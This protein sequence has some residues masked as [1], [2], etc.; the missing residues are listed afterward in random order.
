MSR[1]ASIGRI[2]RAAGLF[3]GPVLFAGALLLD[4][5][6]LVS[7]GLPLWAWQTFAALLFVGS[8]AAIIISQ[9]RRIVELETRSS[10]QA[11]DRELENSIED[12]ISTK[13]KIQAH[14]LSL[15]AILHTLGDDLAVGVSA[16]TGRIVEQLGEAPV[17]P[18]AV[19]TAA[20]KLI[21]KQ[22]VAVERLDWDI[23]SV[24][25]FRLTPLGARVVDHLQ[26][27]GIGAEEFERERDSV[28]LIRMGEPEVA[29]R[30]IDLNGEQVQARVIS[31]PVTN[32]RAPA[33]R[34]TTTII[35]LLRVKSETEGSRQVE[36]PE[37]G[38]IE[39]EH[40]RWRDVDPLVEEITIDRGET[41]HAELLAVS[42][43]TPRDAHLPSAVG[44]RPIGRSNA[45]FIADVRLSADGVLD[46]FAQIEIDARGSE[47]VAKKKFG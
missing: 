20:P 13:V 32:E 8:A 36:N 29:S 33:M 11:G 28:P 15:A 39:N 31:L 34:V 18:V 37:E 43:Q 35:R 25:I 24:D 40:L 26:R 30:S 21:I 41:K 12:V 4:I 45:K 16:I 9:H 46:Q 22:L 23:G 2:A 3:L 17:S 19:E 47:I 27:E 7:L 42:M 1:V 44:S 38:P 10:E 5:L 14:E 6:G